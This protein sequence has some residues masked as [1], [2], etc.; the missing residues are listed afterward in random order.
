MR[1]EAVIT[2]DPHEEDGN[3]SITDAQVLIASMC[4]L[5]YGPCDMRHCV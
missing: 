1:K 3:H 5:C 4:V 2:W